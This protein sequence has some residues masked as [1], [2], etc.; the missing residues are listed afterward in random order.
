MAKGRKNRSIK[1][2]N[3]G[4]GANGA[5]G[6]APKDETAGSQKEEVQKT[7]ETIEE[8]NEDPSQKYYI[9]DDMEA[10]EALSILRNDGRFDFKTLGH[11]LPKFS[12]DLKEGKCKAFDL[13]RSMITRLLV[14]VL[15]PPGKYDSG[16]LEENC[17]WATV[18]GHTWPKARSSGALQGFDMTTLDPNAKKLYIAMV[19]HLRDQSHEEEAY[20]YLFSDAASFEIS[21]LKLLGGLV[22]K[23]MFQATLLKFQNQVDRMYHNGKLGMYRRNCSLFGVGNQ[24][25]NFGFCSLFRLLRKNINASDVDSLLKVQK[26]EVGLAFGVRAVRTGLYEAHSLCWECNSPPGDQSDNQSLL[27]C[28]QCRVCLFCSRECQRKS[29]LGGHR[30]VCQDVFLRSQILMDAIDDV[31]CAV[32]KPVHGLYFIPQICFAIASEFVEPE[33]CEPWV[34]ELG[35]DGPSMKYFFENCAAIHQNKFWIFTDA[36]SVDRKQLATTVAPENLD[37]A[38][39]VARLMC[40]DLESYIR[41]KNVDTKVDSAAIEALIP[42]EAEVIRFKNNTG[43][44]LSPEAFIY[45]LLDAHEVSKS[46]SKAEI[47]SMRSVAKWTGYAHVLRKFRK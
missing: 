29:W 24:S 34:K 18:V 39:S 17:V 2:K 25:W 13:Y 46:L 21:M 3:K 1:K 40:F 30:E 41:R 42:P 27:C 47:R 19:Y 8:Q 14:Y 32:G 10:Q 16:F 28:S 11:Q 26:I 7:I 33:I 23:Q 6:C 4:R 12:S 38:L 31:K 5:G 43:F 44:S 9:V 15:K 37:Y 35:I 45:M 20:K 36:P 22:E